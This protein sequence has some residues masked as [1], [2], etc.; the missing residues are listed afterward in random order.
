M[1]EGKRKSVNFSRCGK[2]QESVPLR[3][4]WQYVIRK[5]LGI[6]PGFAILA[7]RKDGTQVI[8][9]KIESEE[10]KKETWNVVEELE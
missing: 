3:D 7:T 2:Q 10:N 1:R 8:E 6:L 5:E 9:M 4:A